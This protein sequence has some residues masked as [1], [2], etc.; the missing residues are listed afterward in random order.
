MERTMNQPSY[1]SRPQAA[2]YLR[3]RYGLR[4]AAQTLAKYAWSGEGPQFCKAGKQALYSTDWLDAW[5]T[6]RIGAPQKST[7]DTSAQ[8]AA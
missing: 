3:T 1:K 5:A 7:S 6:A 8:R 2:E 4:V